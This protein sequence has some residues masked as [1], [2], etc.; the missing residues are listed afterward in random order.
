MVLVLVIIA[1]ALA[2]VS[3]SLNSI[4]SEEKVSTTAPSGN[5]KTS[6]IGQVGVIVSPPL[7]ED[8]AAAG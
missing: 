2:I 5:L 7:V 1:L 6:E 3:I 8:K 4:S